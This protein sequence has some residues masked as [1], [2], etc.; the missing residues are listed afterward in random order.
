MWDLFRS[1]LA[2]YGLILAVFLVLLL[3]GCEA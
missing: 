2:A 3:A 1:I